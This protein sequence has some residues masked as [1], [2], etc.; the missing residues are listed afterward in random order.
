MDESFN[1]INIVGV[2]CQTVLGSATKGS[3]T[4]HWK[5]TL[6]DILLHNSKYPIPK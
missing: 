3:Q 2:I 6:E 4:A 5:I 1:H